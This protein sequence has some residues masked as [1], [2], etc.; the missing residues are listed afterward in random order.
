MKDKNIEKKKRPLQEKWLLYLF[1]NNSMLF[2]PVFG[3]FATNHL[4]MVWEFVDKMPE[5]FSN[6][7][8]A[9]W[10]LPPFFVAMFYWCFQLH[11]VHIVLEPIFLIFFAFKLFKE[12]NI[13]MFLLILLLTVISIVLNLFWSVYGEYPMGV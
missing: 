2:P 12:K 5:F 4:P 13:K 3:F 11:Y 6:V 9:I 8:L 7:L 10:Y 1:I